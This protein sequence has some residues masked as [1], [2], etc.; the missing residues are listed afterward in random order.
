VKFKV[1]S[2]VHQKCN[3]DLGKKRPVFYPTGKPYDT[4]ISFVGKGSQYLS[5][6]SPLPPRIYG[7]L[8]F[9][10]VQVYP[11]LNNIRLPGVFKLYL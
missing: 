2:G 9:C 10:N 8:D 11:L 6:A 3:P 5:T 4:R 7:L 1:H